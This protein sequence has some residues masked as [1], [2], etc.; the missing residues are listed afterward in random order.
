MKTDYSAGPLDWQIAAAV[1]GQVD[2]YAQI[3][4]PGSRSWSIIPGVYRKNSAQV[5]LSMKGIY[6][7]DMEYRTYGTGMSFGPRIDD[8]LRRVSAEE[9]SRC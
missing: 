1:R 9:G 4:F 6:M 7:L 2:R 8:A 3:T 5:R